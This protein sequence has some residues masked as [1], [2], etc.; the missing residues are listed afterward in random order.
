MVQNTK[1]ILALVLLAWVFATMAI[2]P[3]YLESN[4][5]LVQQTYLRIAGAFFLSFLFL[6]RYTHKA[7]LETV[8]LKDF[9]VISLRAISLYLGVLLF[10]EAVL[11]TK[12]ANA[13]FIAA[14]PLLPIFGYIFFKES[15][16]I[17]TVLCILVGF[18]GVFLIATGDSLDFSFGYG[19]L[20]ALLSLLAFDL[21][22]VA[23]RW[24]T[25]TLNNLESACLMFGVGTIFLL[26]TSFFFGEGLPTA[27][28]FTW[29]TVSILLLAAIFNI[30]NL[31]LTNYGFKNVKVAVAGNIIT[32]ETIFALI[33]GLVLFNEI[34]VLREIVGSLLVL[35]SIYQVNKLEK[36]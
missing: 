16:R 4:F 8:P 9:F 12:L 29:F 33:Y 3:R 36:N 6:L 22:Y 15:L 11:H 26:I 5:L 35:L 24:H 14:L 7:K 10:T 20:M 13:S 31:Y 32:L 18:I 1:A 23:R 27:S 28:Q 19:E 2:F 17:K 21:S 25:D 30:A 34:P